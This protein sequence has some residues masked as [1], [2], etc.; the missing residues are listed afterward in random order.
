MDATWRY[1]SR[2]FDETLLAGGSSATNF[3]EKFLNEGVDGKE[4]RCRMGG[5][6]RTKRLGAQTGNG[7]QANDL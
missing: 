3:A 2:P 4:K 1:D 5:S 7:M 6:P